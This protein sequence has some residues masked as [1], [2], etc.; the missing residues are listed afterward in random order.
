MKNLIK[1]WRTTSMGLLLIAGSLTTL[2]FAIVNHTLTEE[3]M[4][5]ISLGL[6]SG[7]G[8]LAGADA[9]PTTPT[10]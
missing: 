3:K 2:G 9:P 1:N 10:K 4:T 7:F 8:F 6:I 5:G